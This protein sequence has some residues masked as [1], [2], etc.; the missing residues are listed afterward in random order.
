MCAAKE[1]LSEQKDDADSSAP[2]AVKHGIDH[3]SKALQAAQAAESTME[4]SDG[5]EEESAADMHKKKMIEAKMRVCLPLS[6]PPPTPYPF[7][8]LSSPLSSLHPTIR[9]QR[10]TPPRP[11]SFSLLKPFLRARSLSACSYRWKAWP[12]LTRRRTFRP[13]KT[14]SRTTSRR[15]Q[16]SAQKLATC[17]PSRCP[18]CNALA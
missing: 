18:T 2:S 4:D 12:R 1:Q 11:P 7:Y 6:L 5:E 9:N 10:K 14:K 13:C 3:V 17:R 8:F 15:S 16:A